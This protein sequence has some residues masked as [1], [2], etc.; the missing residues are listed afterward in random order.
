MMAD[1]VTPSPTLLLL[2]VVIRIKNS[3][4][5]K[6]SGAQQQWPE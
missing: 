6:I 4:H 1:Y 2:V 3:M 5:I